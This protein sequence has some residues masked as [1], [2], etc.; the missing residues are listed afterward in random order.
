[1]APE[2]LLESNAIQLRV[3]WVLGNFTG[4]WCS[5]CQGLDWSMTWWFEMRGAEPQEDLSFCSIL[6][7]NHHWFGC[8]CCNFFWC[9]TIVQFTL[10]LLFLLSCT[11]ATVQLSMFAAKE[12]LI[13]KTSEEEYSWHTAKK[14]KTNLAFRLQL[15]WIL[16]SLFLLPSIEVLYIKQLFQS[17]LTWK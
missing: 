4:G 11:K 5:S 12:R 2:A 1:M 3:Q 17:V 15:E 7:W 13:H 10:L 16:F 9:S 6:Y 14:N 8:F